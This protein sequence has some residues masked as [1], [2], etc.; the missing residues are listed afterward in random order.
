MEELEI[1]RGKSPQD[2][3]V[4][5]LDAFEEELEVCLFKI[6]QGQNI[7]IDCKIHQSSGLALFLYVIIS[8]AVV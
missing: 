3:W 5:D 1:L 7:V 6:C 2:L 4:E 8:V